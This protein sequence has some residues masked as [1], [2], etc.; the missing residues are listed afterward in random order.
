MLQYRFFSFY[1]RTIGRLPGW[2]G[3][4]L[5]AFLCDI[6]YLFN[7][8]AR[9]VTMRNVSFALGP[10]ATDVQLRQAARGCFRA[11]GAYYYDLARTPRLDGRR[12]VQQNV[13]MNGFERLQ[14]AAD[15]G[16]GV[17]VATIHYGNP[18]YVS[19]GLSATGMRFLALVEPLSPPPLQTMI[20]RLR[21]SQQNTFLPVG[22]S[23]I[24]QAIRHVKAGGILCLMADRDI[25]HAGE[26][27]QFFGATARIP[28]GAVD[29]ARHTGALLLPVV[30]RRLKRDRFDLHVMPPLSLIDTGRRDTDRRL[31][32]ERLIQQF[33]PFIR[34]DPSQWFVLHESI[35]P[36]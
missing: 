26:A 12:F 7:Q 17:I 3:Y 9:R 22:H 16:S 18:E 24:K 20:E 19:Q 27:V 10:T 25:Q 1:C 32:T 21:A 31:N 23:A 33:E 35:W 15:S 29:I 30:A 13:R 28:S 8:P 36:K 14:Q 2:L 34:E 4:P 11:A 5:T 6:A